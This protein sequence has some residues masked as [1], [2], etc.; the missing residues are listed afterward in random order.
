MQQMIWFEFLEIYYEIAGSGQVKWMDY[1]FNY[2]HYIN[3]ECEKRVKWVTYY[4]NEGAKPNTHQYQQ[5]KIM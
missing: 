3:F 4:V 2:F 1:V 5:T